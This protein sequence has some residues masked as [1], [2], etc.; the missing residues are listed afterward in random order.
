MDIT[1]VIPCLNEEKYL[2]NLLDDLAAQKVAPKA[3]IVADCHS[4]DR[5]REVAKE[6]TSSVPIE[7]TLASYKSASSA[8]NA[9]AKFVQTGYLLFLD[10]DTRIPADF[11]EKLKFKLNR[12]YVDFVSPRFK[13]NSPHPFDVLNVFFIN[14]WIV[15][16]MYVVRKPI[17][18]GAAQLVKKSAHDRV[19]GFDQKV[20]EFDD[21]LYTAKLRKAGATFAYAWRAIA[22]FS[23]R[24]VLKQGRFR[25]GIQQLPDNW[26]LVR[27]VVRPLMKRKAISK[28][29][30]D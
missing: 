12:R 14:L 1:V 9:G 21:I 26:F 23:N 30:E 22:I 2:K 5:T 20:R 15:W 13:S 17:G 25:T 10:A 27:K 16:G 3:I 11:I 4:T 19:G 6:Y 24:R 8:R 7:I 28:K 29:F 18:A